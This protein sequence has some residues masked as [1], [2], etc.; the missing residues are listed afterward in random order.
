MCFNLPSQPETGNFC[1][2]LDHGIREI[3]FATRLFYCFSVC[4]H[5]FFS[6]YMLCCGVS[7]DV[8]CCLQLVCNPDLPSMCSS[9]PSAAPRDV[10]VEVINTTVLRV[11]WTPVPVA[12]LRGHL[13][14]YNVRFHCFKALSKKSLEAEIRLLVQKNQIKQN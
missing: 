8:A 12:T 2:A 4:E 14:G 3:Y 5:L 9:V 13:R 7:V 10:A 11:S 1:M 6:L